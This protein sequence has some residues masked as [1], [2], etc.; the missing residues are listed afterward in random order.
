MGYPHLS[1]KLRAARPA[2][3]VAASHSGEPLPPPEAT[4]V[5]GY[6]DFLMWN[7]CINVYNYVA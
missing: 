1:G 2:P 4:E 7:V 3:S 6:G 5:W